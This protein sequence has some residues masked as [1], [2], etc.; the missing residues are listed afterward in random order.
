MLIQKPGQRPSWQEYDAGADGVEIEKSLRT[1]VNRVSNNN[2]TTLKVMA[3]IGFGWHGE[4]V[5]VSRTKSGE[6]VYRNFAQ[7]DL[8][9]EAIAVIEEKKVA[10]EEKEMARIDAEIAA[11]QEKRRV[12]RPPR[13]KTTR[14]KRV[15]RCVCR[16]NE[17]YRCTRMSE[18]GK[19][20]CY[21]HRGQPASYV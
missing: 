6:L 19:S 7:L 2:R 10:D 3:G 20:R 15:G 9:Q 21:Q 13:R 11:I 12:R 4:C 5:A 14:S 8:V 18:P 16:T 17:G 1:L